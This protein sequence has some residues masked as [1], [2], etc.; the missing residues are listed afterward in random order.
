MYLPGDYVARRG[1]VAHALLAC[2]FCLPLCMFV[3]VCC[4]RMY[5]V[6]RGVL[7]IHV[8]DHEALHSFFCPSEAFLGARVGL[9]LLDKPWWG[10]TPPDIQGRP[11]SLP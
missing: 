5:F 3:N 10:S 8:P 4:L 9:N 2:R 6:S 11:E 1:E 7:S